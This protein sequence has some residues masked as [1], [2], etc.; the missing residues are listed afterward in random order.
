MSVLTQT[1]QLRLSRINFIFC[2][3][4]V[5]PY[6][7]VEISSTQ[8]SKDTVSVMTMKIHSI[9]IGTYVETPSPVQSHGEKQRDKMKGV[10]YLNK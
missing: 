10:L 1:Q 9:C 8:S 7:N 6:I 2:N 3:N 5:L 4:L